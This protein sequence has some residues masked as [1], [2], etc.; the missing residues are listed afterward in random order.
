VTKTATLLGVSSATV[1]KVFFQHTQITGRQ[2]QGRG[3][4]GENQHQQK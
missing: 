3:T 4:V 2:H 1:S